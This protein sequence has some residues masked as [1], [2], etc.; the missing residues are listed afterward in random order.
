MTPPF[1]LPLDIEVWADREA[2]LEALMAE[3]NA[4]ESDTL[5][6]LQQEPEGAR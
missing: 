6:E 3:L 1:T 5:D 4:A 2:D